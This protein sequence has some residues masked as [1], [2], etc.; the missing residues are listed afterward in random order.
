[1]KI[2]LSGEQIKKILGTLSLEDIESRLEAN[3]QYFDV[4]WSEEG[5]EFTKKVEKVKG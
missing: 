2:I 1:M 5:Y 3:W 4:E